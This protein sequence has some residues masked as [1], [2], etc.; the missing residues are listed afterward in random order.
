MPT[1]I[2]LTG[3]NPRRV[4]AGKLNRQKSGPLTLAGRER[5]QQAALANRPW[6]HSTGP[7]TIEGKIRVAEHGRK[8]QLGP[9]SVRQL[10]WQIAELY[11]MLGISRR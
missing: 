2:E 10:R 1:S 9:I 11:S 6:E 4:A 8:R 7:R 5:L 3:P